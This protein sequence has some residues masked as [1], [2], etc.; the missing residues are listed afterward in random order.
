M[1]EVS[2]G[3]IPLTLKEGKWQVFLVR[4]RSGHHWG[5]PKGHQ[6]PNET[7]YQT[8][9]RELKEETN[10]LASCIICDET[11]KESYTL[12]RGDV[13]VLKTVT[14]F[15]VEVEGEVFLQK[16]EIEEGRW[17]LLE[18]AAD[19]LTYPQSKALIPLIEKILASL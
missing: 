3:T 10:L 13:K 2:Y 15:L 14:Y 12:L 1:K 4:L 9:L 7:P 16:K 11:I 5:F 18:R 6:E 8:A 17:V 19:L